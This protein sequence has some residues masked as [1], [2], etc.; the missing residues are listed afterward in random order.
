MR[1]IVLSGHTKSLFWFRSDF[2]K[3]MLKRGHE[4]YAIGPDD[5]ATW[6]EDFKKIGLNY[7]Q[8][9]L[10][11]NSLSIMGD[12]KTVKA[13]IALFKEIKPDKIFVDHAKP[14][15]Y[16]SIAARKIKCREFYPMVAGLGSILRDDSLK[17]LPA[18]MVLSFL[19]KRSFSF[20]KKVFVQNKDDAGVLVSRKL[21]SKQKLVMVNGSG[22]NLEKFKPT[23]LPKAVSFLYIG[24]LIRDKGVVEYLDA[25][26]LIHSKYPDTPC[27]LVGPFDTNP[28]AISEAFL[29]PYIDSGVVDYY[30]EQLDVRPYIDQC[31]VLV[32]PSYHEGTPKTVLEAMAKQRA[33]ITSDAPGCRETVTNGENGF[34]VPVRDPEAVAKAMETFIQN[35]TLVETMGRVSKTIA[36]EKYDVKKVNNTIINTMNL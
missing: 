30:G 5:E 24:R 21:V 6:Q 12:I 25:C 27:M 2:M 14:I 9:E 7:R 19:Y 16:G 8:V 4:V 32:L 29:K 26:K 22:V 34:L 28:S 15:A 3:E 17:R 23:P 33:I 13:L 36:E 10:S 1:I 18:R 20:A 31:S 35:P 11:R